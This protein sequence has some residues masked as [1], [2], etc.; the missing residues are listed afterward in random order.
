MLWRPGECLQLAVTITMDCTHCHHRCCHHRCR[1]PPPLYR[2]F[3]LQLQTTTIHRCRSHRFLQC[4]LCCHS[5][6][7]GASLC[8][9]GYTVGLTYTNHTVPCFLLP[10]C[11]K[12]SN[13]H[14]H[15]GKV[16]PPVGGKDPEFP[17]RTWPAVLGLKA[18][19][20]TAT[21]LL[22]SLLTD[23]QD[24]TSILGWTSLLKSSSL[25][26]GLL[27]PFRNS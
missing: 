13:K 14:C 12:L 25:L 19:C 3:P 9:M 8:H 4:E 5:P 17:D 2:G 24:K 16:F 11:K 21:V 23:V 22:T 18:W 6:S 15:I 10:A 20:F 1:L 26:L 27:Q 7:R